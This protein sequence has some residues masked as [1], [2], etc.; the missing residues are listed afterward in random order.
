MT[1]IVVI[2]VIL[3]V[4]LLYHLFK[5]TQKNLEDAVESLESTE[6]L[7]E[8]TTDP[9]VRQDFFSEKAAEMDSEK[10]KT[11]FEGLYRDKYPYLNSYAQNKDNFPHYNEYPVVQ[12]LAALQNEMEFRGISYDLA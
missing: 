9:S 8:D 12:Y 3:G 10:L 6:T 7:V 4:G 2:S 5:D 11:S 1:T